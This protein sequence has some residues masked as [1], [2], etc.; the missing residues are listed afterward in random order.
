MDFLSSLFISIAALF[1]FGQNTPEPVPAP[2]SIEEVVTPGSEEVAVNDTMSE[3]F[4]TA[5]ETV[6]VEEEDSPAS[7]DEEVKTLPEVTSIAATSKPVVED[8]P[9]PPATPNVQTMV[10]AGGC[11][12]CVESDLEKVSGVIS[13]V[14]GYSGG[15][16]ENPTYKN[17]GAGGH[18]EVVEVSYDANVVSFEDIL[19]VTMKT[20]DPTDDDGTFHDRGDKYSSAFYYETAEQKEIIDNLIAE[21][22]EHG[23]YDKPLA[24]DVEKRQTFWPAEEYHQDYYKGT[25]SHL[26]Y[27]Y[28]RNASGRDDFI[29]K[30]WGINDHRSDLP[31]RNQSTITNQSYMWD[32]YKKPAKEVLEEQLSELAFKVTQEEGTERAGTSPLDKNYEPGIYVDILSGEPLYSSKDKYDSGTGWPSFTKPISE[33]AVT[34]HEDK[35]LFSTRTEVRSAIADNHLGH[36]FTDGPKDSTG[37]RYCMNGAALKFIPLGEME[38]AGYGDFIK[39]VE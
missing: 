32:A 21:V 26:K 27:Q 6:V 37:L 36:V 30:Y 18:R 7:P 1:G 2:V 24:I 13:V 38:A 16:T 4:E 33:A 11:F 25:L 3:A 39:Y 15:T 5:N 8:S 29:I 20:T 9:L 22:N 14:S 35:K 31:W 19:I 10:V 34:E 12:W 28:Y 17:Y 23:P